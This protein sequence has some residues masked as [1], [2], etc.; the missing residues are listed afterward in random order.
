MGESASVQVGNEDR[1]SNP[2]DDSHQQNIDQNTGERTGQQEEQLI[3]GKYKTQEDLEKG[4]LELLKKQGGDLEQIYKTLESGKNPFETSTKEEEETKEPDG[5]KIQTD[6]TGEES[7][8]ETKKTLEK[9]DL[10]IEEFEQEFL[11]NGE[12]SQE[13][14]DKLT[15]V[16]PK[17]MVDNYIEGQKLQA[18]QYQNEIFDVA[19]G[20]ENY[21][22]M[23]DW[24]SKNLSNEEIKEF[25]D[26]VSS[27]SKA[28]A[29]LAVQA[30]QQ[31]H[32]T[33]SPGGNLLE[34]DRGGSSG[35][36]GYQSKEEMLADMKDPKYSKDPAFRARVQEKVRNS[37]VI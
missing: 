23:V 12:L 37:S 24:A 25:N 32:Q 1:T 18:Q 9:N 31:A 30:V 20:Q 33:S 19:G 3:A 21:A 29:K 36:P 13:S 10:N 22:A 4:T 11:E 35:S 27:G 5:M 14:Y 7:R 6:N 28:R 8:E 2:R 17:Q 34:G 15:E 16:F 26:A